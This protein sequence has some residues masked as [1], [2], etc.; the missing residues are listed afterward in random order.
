MC[1]GA[2]QRLSSTDK[3]TAITEL[4]H[5]APALGGIGNLEQFERCVLSREEAGSTGL[6]HGVAVAHGKTNLVD[7]VIVTLGISHDGIPFDSPDHRP[8][9]LL[10]LIASPPDQSLEYL[11]A[12]SAIACVFKGSRLGER[13]LAAASCDD[14]REIVAGALH[15]ALARKCD[16]LPAGTLAALLA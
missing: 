10:F 4:I 15:D 11:M 3:L 1:T 14:A 7:R 16:S 2:V 9:N 5:K 8:V 12:L 6:G 13:V